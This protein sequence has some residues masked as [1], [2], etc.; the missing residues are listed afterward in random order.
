MSTQFTHDG[1]DE[2]AGH[3]DDG[4]AADTCAARGRTPRPVTGGGA[5]AS[6]A[7]AAGKFADP[8]VRRFTAR[9]PPRF[10]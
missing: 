1:G 7:D 9:V 3:A 10:W 4:A 5:R 2:P 6:S 8:D